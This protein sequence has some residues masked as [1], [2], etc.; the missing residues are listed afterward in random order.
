MRL[1]LGFGW[2][3]DR[4]FRVMGLVKESRFGEVDIGFSGGYRILSC[5]W[6]I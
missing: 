4:S 5:G 2:F 1:G 6:D 3:G